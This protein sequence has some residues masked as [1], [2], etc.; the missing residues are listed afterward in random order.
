MDAVPGT[1]SVGQFLLIASINSGKTNSP[2]PIT[3]KSAPY[4]FI[5]SSGLAEGHGPPKVTGTFGKISRMIAMILFVCSTS[6]IMILMP[7]KSG[8]QS[9]I[10][11]LNILRS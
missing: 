1:E 10:V 2:S 4:V 9:A 3:T 5:A 7:I 8:F 6:V 11:R